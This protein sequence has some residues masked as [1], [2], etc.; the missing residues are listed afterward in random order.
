MKPLKAFSYG[1]WPLGTSSM[2]LDLKHRLFK[3]HP[4]ETGVS[5][6]SSLLG[7][8]LARGN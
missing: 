7:A 8:E 5:Y 6:A 2:A 4:P 3:A 1:I